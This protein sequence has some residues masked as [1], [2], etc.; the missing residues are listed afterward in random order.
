MTLDA[1]NTSDLDEPM[2]SQSADVEPP[3][4]HNSSKSNFFSPAYENHEIPAANNQPPPNNA[5]HSAKVIYSSKHH[6]ADVG[7]SFSNSKHSVK[8]GK[9]FSNSLHNSAKILRNWDSLTRHGSRIQNEN[10]RNSIGG[11][12]ISRIDTG[13]KRNSFVRKSV[14]FGD[15]LPGGPIDFLLLQ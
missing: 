7:E 2:G 3:L 13:V 4:T 15:T 9:S 8:G 12:R 5:R 6:S 14:T 11:E 1:S 10:L